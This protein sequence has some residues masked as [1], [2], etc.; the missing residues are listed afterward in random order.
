MKRTLF[1]L[2]LLLGLFSYP[3]SASSQNGASLY[4]SPQTGSFFVGGTFTVSIFANT[5]ESYINAVSALL[6]FP[7]DKLQIV[8][9]TGG[10][11]FIS[12]WLTQPE[13]SNIEGTLDLKGGVPS[14]GIKT[15]SGLVTT[16]TFRVKSP[17][18]AIINFNKDSQIL[19]NDGKG[20]NILSS[21]IGGRYRLLVEPPEGPIVASLTHPDSNV[22]YSNSN[23]SFSWTKEKDINNFSYT[24]EQNSKTVPDNVSEGEHVVQDYTDIADGIWYFHIK[25]HETSWGGTTHF[26]VFIDTLAPA[27]FSPELLSKKV[28]EIQRGSVSFITTDS[29]SGLDYYEIKIEDT[30]DQD[31]GTSF[32]FEVSSPYRLPKL[33]TGEYTIIV[34]AYDKAGNWQ[35]EEVSLLVGEV[36]ILKKTFFNY[37]WTIIILVILSILYLDFSESERNLRKANN[38]VSN[39]KSTLGTLK[40]ELKLQL[41]ELEKASKKRSL[42]AKEK[43]IRKQ[44]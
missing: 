35:D 27:S 10:E 36:S 37:W 18:E 9:P 30:D 14:P 29:T 28:S 21:L 12:I 11:S 25:A 5:G 16:V 13:F 38:F 2:F 41:K 34:R 23:P 15:S 32:F 19:K 22:W 8:Q 17:G 6:I 20:T 44:T 43:K 31:N 33:E 4:L 39:A 7:S 3:Y 26:P 40:K 42:T 1:L 24:F